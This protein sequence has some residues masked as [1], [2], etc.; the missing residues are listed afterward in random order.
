[1]V[2]IDEDL[3]VMAA[4]PLRYCFEASAANQNQQAFEGFHVL[5]HYYY[6]FRDHAN[7]VQ[8]DHDHLGHTQARSG[9]HGHTHDARGEAGNGEGCDGIGNLAEGMPPHS[10]GQDWA[11][12]VAELVAV[13]VMHAAAEG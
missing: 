7:H 4:L 3:G 11:R 1:M 9:N 8:L 5:S 13:L 6:L 10:L 12:I 2:T